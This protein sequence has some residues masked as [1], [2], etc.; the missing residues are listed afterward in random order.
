VD[1]V[2]VRDLGLLGDTD[3]NH[4]SHAFTLGRVLVTTDTD[5]LI[6]ASA[7]IEHAGIIFGAQEDHSVGDWV[8]ELELI[9]FVYEPEDMR[10][11]VEF[12]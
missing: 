12:I 5:F 7:G 1:V 8:K 4:L 2:S 11:R 3:D 6:M 9:C 10:N